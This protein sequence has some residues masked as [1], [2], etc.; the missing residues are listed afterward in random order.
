MLLASSS[1]LWP[2]SPASPAAE[3]EYVC[4]AAALGYALSCLNIPVAGQRQPP[5]AGR[6]AVGGLRKARAARKQPPRQWHQVVE[7]LER[8]ENRLAELPPPSAAFQHFVRDSIAAAVQAVQA[9]AAW[10]ESGLSELLQRAARLAEDD[11]AAGRL[12]AVELLD[13]K[14]I[15]ER[16]RSGGPRAPAP[17]PALRPGSNGA[18]ARCRGPRSRP[19]AGQGALPAPRRHSADSGHGTH[20]R[21]RAAGPARARRWS[22]IARR[23]CRRRRG[24]PPRRPLPGTRSRRR[25]ALIRSRPRG[26]ALRHAP[27]PARHRPRARSIERAPAPRPR[28]G[29]SSPSSPI[30]A[31]GTCDACGSAAPCDCVINNRQLGAMPGAARAAGAPAPA[32]GAG[33]ALTSGSGMLAGAMAPPKRPAPGDAEAAERPFKRPKAFAKPSPLTLGSGSGRDAPKEM[34]PNCREVLRGIHSR[35]HDGAVDCAEAPEQ[36]LSRDN[37]SRPDFKQ[38]AGRVKH[39]QGASVAELCPLAIS[40]PQSYMEQMPATLFATDILHRRQISLGKHLTCRCGP[41]PHACSRRARPSARHRC[42][43]AAATPQPRRSPPPDP[44]PARPPARRCS[45]GSL[46]AKQRAS[47]TDMARSQLVAIVELQY[48]ALHLVP[49]FDN[50]NNLKVVGFLKLYT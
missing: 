17:A 50:S 16:A 14:A 25:V 32:P 46:S 36:V 34:P 9:D 30:S 45:L 40:I 37:F 23:S 11:P 24:A 20:K 2:P 21:R 26:P 39:K 42:D 22:R 29:P 6:H 19:A 41:P 4:P 18:G 3:F 15:A 8:D 44:L 13:Y 7:E 47:L 28:A 43:P 10:R 5:G 48:C 31:P 27:R 1:P 35:L 38:W 33:P 12:A 49:Y